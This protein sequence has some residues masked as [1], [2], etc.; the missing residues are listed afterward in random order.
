VKGDGHGQE[1]F[2]EWKSRFYEFGQE[3]P[4]RIGHKSFLA[5]FKPVDSFKNGPFISVWRVRRLKM[6]FCSKA[7]L[8]RVILNL[9]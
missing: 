8:A 6:R 7:I 4:H 1:R 2:R 5:V 9:F 3:R